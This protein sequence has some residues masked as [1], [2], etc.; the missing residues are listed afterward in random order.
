MVQSILTDMFDTVL[1]L[2]ENIWGSILYKLPSE[3][4]I[5]LKVK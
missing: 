5:G 1:R 3:N 2:S 4:D